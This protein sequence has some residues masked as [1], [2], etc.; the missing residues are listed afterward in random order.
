MN[1]DAVVFDYDGTLVRL[2]IDFGAIRQELER[3]ASRYGVAID[4]YKDLYLLEMIDEVS[5]IITQPDG[6]AFR[7]AALALVTAREIEAARAGAVFPGVVDMLRKLRTHWIKTAIITRNCDQ[8]VKILFPDIES[9]CDVYIPRNLVARV[10][11]HPDHLTL[12]MSLMEVS[13]PSRCLMVGD[14]LLDVLAGMRMGMK[15]AGVLT[16]TLTATQ[17]TEAGAD[18]I[19]GEATELIHHLFQEIG[20]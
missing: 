8:A 19:L 3:M 12:A 11:P 14:H 1:I 10:K 5:A 15:T 7:A 9:H 13:D 4:E 6:A 18:F 2:N 17:F 16:G 20:T